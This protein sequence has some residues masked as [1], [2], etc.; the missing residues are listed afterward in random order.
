MPSAAGS[1]LATAAVG[2][3]NRSRSAACM[4]PS[5]APA[6]HGRRQA[7]PVEEGCRGCLPPR[8]TWSREGQLDWP[9]PRTRPPAHHVR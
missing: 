6:A 3:H 9:S 2:C 5:N 7:G 4:S 1:R 8:C